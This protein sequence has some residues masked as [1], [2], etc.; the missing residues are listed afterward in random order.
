MAACYITLFVVYGGILV[1]PQSDDILDKIHAIA[2]QYQ[3][4]AMASAIG[5][6]VF[7]CLLVVLVQ[8]IYNRLQSEKLVLLNTASIFA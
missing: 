1:F 7:G 5:Y 8:A 4:I 3:L 2:S 6:L